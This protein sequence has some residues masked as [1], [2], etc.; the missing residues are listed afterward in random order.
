M[1]R[2]G[3]ARRAKVDHAVDDS[4]ALIVA[5]LTGDKKG[6][7]EAW[8]FHDDLFD[9]VSPLVMMVQVL[10][11]FVDESDPDRTG[12]G[13]LEEIVR[14]FGAMDPGDDPATHDAM[15]DGAALTLTWY[16]NERRASTASSRSIER[17]T[18]SYSRALLRTSSSRC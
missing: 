5:L 1:K 8:R 13:T 11:T 2:G 17:P 9:I 10:G 18:A 16:R 15:R 4:V 3:R 12:E 7:L 14:Q 6:L